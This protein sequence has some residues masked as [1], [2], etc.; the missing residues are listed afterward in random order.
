MYGP[1]GIS[2][3]DSQ[4]VATN[5]RRLMARQ[6]LT[7]EDVVAASGLDER[8]IRSLA[9]GTSRPHARTI[10]KLAEGLGVLSD[11]FFLDSRGPA[12]REFDRETNPLVEQVVAEHPQSF[13]GWTPADFDEL[14]SRFGAGGQ[15]TEA[16][17]LAAAEAMNAKREVLSRVRVILETGEAPLLNS[18]VEI[19]YH[20]VALASCQCSGSGGTGVSPVS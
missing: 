8:T 3:F 7:Y 2:D 20:R 15:L 18:L 13:S 19:L 17:A 6:G 16:G 4:R 10:H 14:Y 9:H 1:V 11:E 5:L 12:C